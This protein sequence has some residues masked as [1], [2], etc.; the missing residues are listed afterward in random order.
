MERWSWVYI[1]MAVCGIV[2]LVYSLLLIVA[3]YFDLFNSLTEVSFYHKL[4]FGNMYPVGSVAN[5]EHLKLDEERKVI[6]A[7]HKTAWISF[8]IGVIA[9]SILLNGRAVVVTFISLVNWFSNL[10]SNI[11][12]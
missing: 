3:Y 1:I 10:I 9:S 11:G 7:T 2:I 6:Y 4:T 8:A 12:G 5:I